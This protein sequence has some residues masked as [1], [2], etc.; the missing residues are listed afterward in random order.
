MFGISVLT[1][2]LWISDRIRCRNGRRRTNFNLS[3]VV[4]IIVDHHQIRHHNRH[5]YNSERQ[6]SLLLDFKFCLMVTSRID[7]PRIHVVF[8]RR[9]P[10]FYS[11]AARQGAQ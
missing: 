2:G 1:L 11:L 5:R 3:E 4:M 10:S 6:S 7:T 9:S 8:A